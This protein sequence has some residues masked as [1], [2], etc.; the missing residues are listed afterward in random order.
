MDNSKGNQELTN[1]SQTATVT[2]T[3]I[4][5]SKPTTLTQPN[6]PT[7]V[8]NTMPSNFTL[9]ILTNTN[10]ET[11]SDNNPRKR[12]NSPSTI[13]PTLNYDDGTR[14]IKRRQTDQNLNSLYINSS[15]K[16]Q[17]LP[18]ILKHSSDSIST[19]S[20]SSK[21]NSLAVV[22]VVGMTATASNST[23][24]ATGGR[25]SMTIMEDNADEDNDDIDSNSN[26]P[27]QHISSANQQY[28]DNATTP[29]AIVPTSPY[30]SYF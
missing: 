4:N 9:G 7:P 16:Q 14:A 23:L 27:Q 10:N 2:L 24:M 11:S 12:H 8:E 5:D 15:N 17:Q 13:R 29:N 30:Y 22:D 26:I 21:S 19:Y 1:Y 25:F 18:C 28:I 3:H 6:P 20:I